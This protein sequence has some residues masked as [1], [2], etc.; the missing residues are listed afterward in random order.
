M[1]KMKHRLNIL[2]NMPDLEFNPIEYDMPYP[3]SSANSSR[4]AEGEAA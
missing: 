2:H 4:L 1:K 3:S